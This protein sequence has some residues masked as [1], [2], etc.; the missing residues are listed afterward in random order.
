MIR[1]WYRWRLFLSG[2]PGLIFLLW[3]WHVMPVP[4]ASLSSATGRK[5]LIVGLSEQKGLAIHQRPFPDAPPAGLRGFRIHSYRLIPLRAQA[6]SGLPPAMGWQTRELDPGVVVRDGFV[7]YWAV[8]ACYSVAWFV[9]LVAWQRRQRRG[10]VLPV[11]G[12]PPG[13]LAS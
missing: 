9:V 1:P 8:S 12:R 7:A 10:A 3:A 2:L 4:N 11:V 5:Q 13:D 6:R